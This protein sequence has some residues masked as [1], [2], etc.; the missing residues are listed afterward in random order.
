VW[1]N[2]TRPADHGIAELKDGEHPVLGRLRINP[3]FRR[4]L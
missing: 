1:G 4:A 3:T 2:D